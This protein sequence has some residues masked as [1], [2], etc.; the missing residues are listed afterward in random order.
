MGALDHKV[1]VLPLKGLSK[2]R[3]ATW[4]ICNQAPQNTLDTKA[5]VRFPIWGIYIL[6]HINAREVTLSMMPCGENNGSSTFGTYNI[7]VLCNSKP[8]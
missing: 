4:V 5:Q 8:Q 3:T 7:S 6:S 1:S 2:I